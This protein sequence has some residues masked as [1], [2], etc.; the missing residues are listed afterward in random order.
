MI[1]R[2][3]KIFSNN[4][5]FNLISLFNDLLKNIIESYN[6]KNK[7]KSVNLEKRIDRI[8]EDLLFLNQNISEINTF[9]EFE[10]IEDELIDMKFFLEN[11]LNT[12]PPSLQKSFEKLYNALSLLIFNL[13]M[14]EMDN[15]IK[16]YRNQKISKA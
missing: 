12:F 11:N 13:S 1:H 3:K 10:K 7:Q 16:N 6:N 2:R 8:V 15:E 4:I 5:S 14:Y 9:P